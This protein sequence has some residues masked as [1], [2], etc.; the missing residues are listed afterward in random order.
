MKNS[1]G[2]KIRPTEFFIKYYIRSIRMFL[3]KA[4]IKFLLR[5]FQTQPERNRAARSEPDEKRA[6]VPGEAFC[7]FYAKIV[8]IVMIIQ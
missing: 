8:D 3:C 6:D 4:A 5:F 1:V 7:G 2:R